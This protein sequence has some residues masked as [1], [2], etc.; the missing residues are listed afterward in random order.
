VYEVEAVTVHELGHEWFY[1]MVATNEVE[2]PFLD[3]GINTFAEETCSEASLGPGN[4][5]DVFGLQVGALE[6]AGDAS[7]LAVHDAPVAQPAYAFTAGFDL[8]ALV[9]AR[10]GAIFGTLRRVYGDDA[11]RALG[12]YARKYRFQHPG[13]DELFGVYRRLMGDAVEQTLR[14]A[15]YEKGWVDY[16]ITDVSGGRARQPA[17][18]FERDGKRETVANGTIAAGYDG[19]VLVMRRGTLSF[20]VE[21]DLVRADGSKERVH[22]DGEGSAIRI[23]YHSDQPL[24]AAL[25]DPDHKIV[26]EQDPMNDFATAPGAPLAGAP[27]T[28]ERFLYWAEL[29]FQAVLP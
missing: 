8:G 16:A 13:P 23:P 18:I 1:G 15:L 2:W 21:I 22:W 12:R 26:I 25:I 14:T 19:S 10:T 28:L 3:E 20:P 11:L 24:R 27:R 6:A 5:V 7:C 4:I 17:G 9:Y 29:A